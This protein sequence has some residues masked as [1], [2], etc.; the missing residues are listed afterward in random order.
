MR[1]AEKIINNL[2]F[3]KKKNSSLVSSIEKIKYH[4]L[5]SISSI[6]DNKNFLTD[7]SLGWNALHYS[8]LNDNPEVLYFLLNLY[9]KHEI[10][11]NTPISSAKNGCIKESNALDISIFNQKL[12]HFMILNHFGL[13][14]HIPLSHFIIKNKNNYSSSELEEQKNIYKLPF[15]NS[16]INLFLLNYKYEGLT[17]L[18]KNYD[19]DEKEFYIDCFL[20][21][22]EHLCKYY[23]TST[24]FDSYSYFFD[25][26]GECH[27]LSINKF[28]FFMV[29]FIEGYKQ[30]NKDKDIEFKYISYLNKNVKREDFIE[31]FLNSNLK[32]ELLS[33]FNEMTNIKD[34][35]KN[36]K[37]FYEMYEID[38]ILLNEKLHKTIQIKDSQIKG[39]KI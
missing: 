34:N 11:L 37:Q 39:L 9:Q 17:L 5:L 3:K 16:V 21:N 20:K 2:E 24:F 12:N 19:Y 18:E 7:F 29:Y 15:E 25:K 38:K 26:I 28:D 8:A 22:H 6:I 27:N 32:E 36:I 1:L 30:K 10:S 33:I 13:N 31:E 14:E 4:D 23:L 35:F